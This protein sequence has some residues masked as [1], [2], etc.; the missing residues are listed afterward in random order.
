MSDYFK[1]AFQQ[2]NS[3]SS[4]TKERGE[5]PLQPVE[6]EAEEANSLMTEAKALGVEVATPM[7]T[8]IAASPLLAF[9][10][11]GWVA[12][13]LVQAFSGGGSN[14]L[15][16]S[17]RDPDKEISK[18][19]AGA[20]ALFSMIPGIAPAKTA[21]LGKLGTVG[22]RAAEGA[23]MA[24]G[25]ETTRQAFEIAE[26]R[27][28]TMSPFEI[29]FATV[30]G[31]SIGGGLGRLESSSMINRMGVS[32]SD[33]KKIQSRM[34]SEVA[35][36]INKIDR[37]LKKNPELNDGEMGA[38]LRKEKE[39][40]TQQL[41]EVS[42]TDREYLQ[43]LQ[44]KAQEEKAKLEKQFNELAL[45]AQGEPK[46]GEGT[47]LRPEGEVPV[48]ISQKFKDYD[49]SQ[50]PEYIGSM[51]N[52]HYKNVTVGEEGS[53]YGAY[54]NEAGEI[55]DLRADTPIRIDKTL[56]NLDDDALEEALRVKK[57]DLEDLENWEDDSK[58]PKGDI[59]KIIDLRS[60]VE[61]FELE[62]WRRNVE[63][64][65]E[66]LVKDPEAINDPF[67]DLFGKVWDE[68][69]LD[70]D[71]ANVKVAM[72]FEAIKK[73]GLEDKFKDFLKGRQ[74]S[75]GTEVEAEDAEFLFKTQMEKA[76]NAYKKFSQPQAEP[77]ADAPA[78]ESKAP[79]T[80]ESKLESWILERQQFYKDEYLK[81]GGEKIA[82]WEDKALQQV[83][84]ELQ[85][86]KL[87][88]GLSKEDIEGIL[89]LTKDRETGDVLGPNNPS[90]AGAQ[91]PRTG[92]LLDFIEGQQ[93]KRL[94][95]VTDGEDAFEWAA[96]QQPSKL[97]D[98]Q[99]LEALNRMDMSDEDLSAFIEGKTQILPINIGT[100]TNDTDLQRSI[101]A[102]TE[103]VKAGFKKSGVKTDKESLLKRAQELRSQ[104]NPDVDPVKY[105][106]DIAK[107]SEDI[108]FETVVADSLML[109]AFQ[110][111]N[112]KIGG[113]L[114]FNDPKTLNDLM[115]DLDRLGEFVDHSSTISSSAGKLL[116]SRKVSRDQIAAVISDME[117]QTAKAEKEITSDLIKYSK[118][119]K[120]E[121]LQKQ[122]EKLGGLKAIRG[123]TNELRLVRDN[124][125]LGRL[126]EITRKS[127]IRKF[128]D[129]YMELRYDF[130]LSAPT[131]QGAAA[132]GNALMSLY[133]LS[134]QAIG[135]MLTKGGLKQS[136]HAVRTAKNLMASLPDAFKAAKL[137]AKNSQGQMAL[138]SH[139]EKVGGK[140]FSMEETGFKGAV[141]ESVE[142]LGEL[143]SFGPKGLVFQDEFYRHM[144][145]KAQVKSLLTDEYN[146]LIR[147]GEAPVGKLDEYI[148]GKMSRYFVDGKR[149][150]TKNDINMEAVAQAR[151]QNLEGDEAVEFV[152]KYLKDNWTEKL[153]SEMEYMKDFG[154]RVTFQQ[155]LSKD[156]NWFERMG[157]RV[158]DERNDNLFV[159]YLVPFIKTPVNIFKEFG[160]TTSQI[161]EL[162]FV[163]KLWARTREELQSDNPMVRAQAR[164]R[165][166]TGG[167][168][169]MSAIYLADQQ[170]I[171]G[172]GPRDYKEL[173]NKKNAGWMPNSI[174]TSALKR[175]HETGDSGGDQPGDNYVSL[176]RADPLATITGFAADMRRAREDNDFSE[177]EFT[178][179]LQVTAFS[180]ARAVGQKSYLETVGSAL[181]ALTSG[182]AAAD[183]AN[184][185]EAFLEEFVRGNTPAI[186]NAVG[187][188]EDP[189]I[190]EV[191]GPIEMLWNRLGSMSQTLNPRRDAFGQKVK[192]SGGSNVKRELNA[193]LPT[194]LSESTEDKATQIILEIPGRY[195]FPPANKKIPGIDLNDMKV[196]GTNQSL[197]DRWQEIYSQSSVKEDVIEAYENP[198]VQQFTRPTSGSTLKD[199]Q[200]QTINNVMQA[201]REAAFA[202]LLE[203]YPELYEQYE[204]QGDLQL[205]QLGGEQIP[206]EMVAPGLRE[207]INN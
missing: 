174:N 35:S 133:S 136:K 179:L 37:M 159:Q 84:V 18:G 151:E 78:I 26:G 13:G 119:L 27:R 194:T 178:Y 154:D 12:Y 139:Y 20:A 106:K 195:S 160:G 157:S 97:T 145:A 205:K 120:P 150:K 199:L 109:S 165:Q 207:L 141:G 62:D 10:P 173:Q 29:G 9:G 17:I 187:R 95:E 4:S 7:A 130:I 85:E 200:K 44:Q 75:L 168:L 77:K 66:D 49:E 82:G 197:Y 91:W 11:K 180:I 47:V 126:L 183:D 87:P 129:M 149:F 83:S 73:H 57:N 24:G 190:R 163:G 103:Q 1:Q 22:V 185:G 69:K 152:Q 172:S 138:N 105:S 158:Q 6:P 171:T 122:L 28:E 60:E 93:S 33:A 48:G 81:Q 198:D 111:W 88:P 192:S 19:E 51:E 32:S 80:N 146:Q 102:V 59:E 94:D 99:K 64:R 40:L 41:T 148:E 39:D 112:S 117:K 169:W 131:T 124:G 181:E 61:A 53:E 201:H 70:N 118:D 143:M 115:A 96:K 90:Q 42:R 202:Q 125:K 74:R 79:T 55:I 104:L 16:Q 123:F 140:A 36:R 89:P 166:I 2:G 5:Q 193:V 170:I 31:S 204:Y 72:A 107:K 15:A 54:M 14:V 177:D 167:A 23:V 67:N 45:R 134:N 52:P 155:E 113:D 184:Y 114:D 101:A 98:E 203:E 164:G 108:I 186:L 121:E 144:F 68:V 142:N 38:Q 189:Y 128:T 153:S 63:W 8:G 132:M 46:V 175:F 110:N 127:G 196:P 3:D 206:K 147:R 191:N 116:Q 162:P 86:G 176:Q 156:Y 188:S 58:I 21:K 56:E 76:V 34:E 43:G 135:G 182:R 25:E 65:A 100:I 71:M 50:N 137:A 92:T 161:A 30:I